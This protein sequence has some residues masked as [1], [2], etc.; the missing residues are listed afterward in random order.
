M[1]AFLS[2]L[3][4][5]QPH[6]NCIHLF[7]VSGAIN[8]CHQLPSHFAQGDEQLQFPAPLRH[9]TFYH[10]SALARPLSSSICPQEAAY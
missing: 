9:S 8:Y 4:L 5:A 3:D 2:Q 1:F 7:G 10:L 6:M